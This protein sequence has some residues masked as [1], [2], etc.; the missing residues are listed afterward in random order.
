MRE[1]YDSLCF[2]DHVSKF[3]S[4]SATIILKDKKC[5]SH[6]QPLCSLTCSLINRI[7]D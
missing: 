5:I 7:L 2:A 1:D 6:A 3:A 4:K